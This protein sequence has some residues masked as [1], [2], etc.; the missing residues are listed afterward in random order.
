MYSGFTTVKVTSVVNQAGNEIIEFNKGDVVLAVDGKTIEA[1]RTFDMLIRDYKEG[2]EF[3]VTVDRD[4]K[5]EDITVQKQKLDPFYFVSNETYFEGKTFVYDS[6]SRTYVELSLDTFKNNILAISTKGHEAS[7]NGRYDELL[8]AYLSTVYVDA[9]GSATYA[10]EE[11][12]WLVEGNNEN[13]SV[14]TYSAGGTSIGIIQTYVG[15]DYGFFESLLKAW[16]YS[17]YLCDLILDALWGL[18]TGATPIA[19]MGGTIT[20]V[21]QIAQISQMSL[22]HFL[23][24][25]PLLSMN[26]AVFNILP[27]PSLDGARTL[28]VCWEW[29]AR[30]PVNRKIEGLIHTIGL[31]LLLGLV[32]FFDIYH[33]FIAARLLI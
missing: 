17:F 33:F 28:F 24:L 27:F 2:D 22:S 7:E 15:K 25:I 13:M 16:P 20:A 11:Y 4:G 32:V 21:G 18:F 1:Y 12:S 5:V 10:D 3:I 26:L 6:V 23:L 29:I 30:K 31:F 14:I 9:E 8:N 19:E